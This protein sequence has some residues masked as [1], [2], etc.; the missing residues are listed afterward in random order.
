M[1]GIKKLLSRAEAE[2]C[3]QFRRT[4]R[5][6]YTH[7]GFKPSDSALDTLNRLTFYFNDF[8]DARAQLLAFASKEL[9]NRAQRRFNA[10]KSKKTALDPTRLPPTPQIGS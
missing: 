9:E 8:V 1:R 4:L 6:L 3:L 7:S 10:P 2:A 5:D